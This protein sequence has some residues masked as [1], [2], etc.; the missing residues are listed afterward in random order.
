MKVYFESLM[1]TSKMQ[2]CYLYISLR[3]L[4]WSDWGDI[5]KIEMSDLTGGNRRILVSENIVHPRGITVDYDANAIYWVDSSK[6]TVE[7]VEFN[8]N[9]RRIVL[10]L[11]NTNFFGIALYEV[12]IK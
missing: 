9:N 7:T 4:F 11:P 2:L 8:G 5:P 10:S 6:D 3:Y 12:S 1:K